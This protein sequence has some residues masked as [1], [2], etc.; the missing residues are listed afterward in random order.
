MDKIYYGNAAAEVLDGIIDPALMVKAMTLSGGDEKKGRAFYIELRAKELEAEDRKEKVSRIVNS[1]ASAATNAASGVINHLT[2]EETKKEARTAL[3]FLLSLVL[4]TIFIIIAFVVF[5]SI[6][7]Q[8][9]NNYMK[10]QNQGTT[11]TNIPPSSLVSEPIPN[12]GNGRY[13][14][15]GTRTC[16]MR[17]HPG[18]CPDRQYW[19]YDAGKCKASKY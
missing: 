13:Y 6:A 1:T 16:A 7:G 2:R 15:L 9:A 3:K 10:Q 8:H 4:G 14:D 12:C 17:E 18:R 11:N 5:Y 19:D